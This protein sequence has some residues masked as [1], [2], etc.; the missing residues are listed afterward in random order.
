VPDF[1]EKLIDLKKQIKE[2]QGKGKGIMRRVLP[3]AL[4]T[5]EKGVST[6][7]K[8]QQVGLPQQQTQVPQT[9]GQ[10]ADVA[11][12]AQA[13]VDIAKDVATGTQY[14]ARKVAP[15]A[16]QT[17]LQTATKAA[18]VVS[19]GVGVAAK[20]LGPI[21]W[22][23]EI[24]QGVR[25]VGAAWRGEEAKHSLTG[26]VGQAAGR[27]AGEA[28]YGKETAQRQQRAQQQVQQSGQ[29]MS[30]RLQNAGVTN[31][32]E[33]GALFQMAKAQGMDINTYAQSLRQKGLNPT[34]VARGQVQPQQQAT[35]VAQAPAQQQ[36][37]PTA[38]AEVIIGLKKIANYLDDNKMFEDAKEVDKIIGII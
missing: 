37:T 22:G 29:A 26:Q 14:I 13:K 21:G 8:A 31:D 36:A 7:G 6:V 30:Q 18:P 11:G 1:K 35:A 25:D 23:V 15:Q 32:Q 28:V 20:A 2:A 12:A 24:A 27:A 19:K 33:Y 4:Q 3:K 38:T 5:Y 10:A 9:W 16:T 34:A 17:A